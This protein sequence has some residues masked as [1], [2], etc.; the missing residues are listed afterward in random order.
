[1]ATRFLLTVRSLSVGLLAAMAMLA[2]AQPE[3][4]PPPTRGQM[5]YSTHCIECHNTQMHWRARQQARDWST[6]RV[7]VYRW[8]AAASLGWSDADIDEVTRYL[9]DTIYQFDLPQPRA[10]ARACAMKKRSISSVASG[11]RGSV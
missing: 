9:N 7:E 2:I 8:Q 11:P 3:V 10:D 5:L 4:Q 6:L 1:M